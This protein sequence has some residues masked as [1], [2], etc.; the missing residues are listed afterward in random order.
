MKY[1]YQFKVRTNIYFGI[2]INY[3]LFAY[4]NI[5]VHRNK[6]SN[7]NLSNDTVRL[8]FQSSSILL[9]GNANFEIEKNLILYI[10]LGIGKRTQ[11]VSNASVS[12]IDSLGKYIVEVGKS[13]D[14]PMPIGFET[15][16][17]CNYYFFKNLGAYW[18]VGLAK[19]MIQ[20]GIIFRF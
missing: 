14:N 16:L 13:I 20:M 11:N 3:A 15:T 4:N 19:S 7:P 1:A 17:G 6:F 5:Y 18:E 9:R 2:G 12:Y 10:G 8:K